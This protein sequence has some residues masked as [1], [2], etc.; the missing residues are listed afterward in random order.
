[1]KIARLFCLIVLLAACSR[2]AVEEVDLS[3]YFGGLEGTAVFYEPERGQYKVYNRALSEK[4]S[5]PC[6]TFKIMSAFIGLKQG[7]ISPE[8]SRRAWTHT[9]YWNKAWNKDMEL[10][11]AFSTSCVWYFRRLIDEAGPDVLR[12]S[13]AKWQY[14]NQDISDW[15][16]AEND[17]ENNPD[18]KGFWIES[19]LKISPREQVDFLARLFRRKTAEVAA[20]KKIMLVADGPVKVYGKTGMGVK[21][22]EIADAWFV[23]FY[24]QNGQT[25]FFAVRL[26]DRRRDDIPDYR[27]SAGLIA[28]K[29]ALDII[30]RANLF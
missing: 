22:D 29:I 9:P 26:N 15:Q 23:G 5:S 20:L 13:L 25:V 30:G 10:A 14:G 18:L 2:P 12:Q 11:E 28:R 7:L 3:A 6:S 17:N 8:D 24:E 16:G 19:S 1:M 27:S 21:N 4:R